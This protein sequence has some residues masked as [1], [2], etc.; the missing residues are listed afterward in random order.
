MKVTN[1][2]KFKTTQFTKDI[3]TGE[4][5]YLF[6]NV[7]IPT[8]DA[9]EKDVADWTAE[10]MAKSDELTW[11]PIEKRTI[12]KEIDDLNYK[13]ELTWLKYSCTDGDIEY[14]AIYFWAWEIIDI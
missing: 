10:T 6:K 12:V 8:Y 2:L 11:R 5:T 7:D 1:Y 13:K 3:L 9:M 4:I 14:V